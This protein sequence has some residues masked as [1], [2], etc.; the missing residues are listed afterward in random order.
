VSVTSVEQLV[1]ELCGDLESVRAP[2]GPNLNA[3]SWQ[4]EAPLRMLLNNLDS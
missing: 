3:G 1:E 2:R 4:T